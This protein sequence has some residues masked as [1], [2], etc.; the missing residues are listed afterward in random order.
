MICPVGLRGMPSLDDTP[1][2]RP[3]G[4]LDWQQVDASRSWDHG[5]SRAARSPPPERP[6]VDRS[7]V[8]A[9]PPARPFAET[10]DAELIGVLVDPAA[11]DAEPPR[12]LRGA[13]Q[14][15]AGRSI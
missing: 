9:Q 12:D 13:E 2:T 1:P 11:L 14:A 15:G 3:R 6:L 5:R 8:E 10:H 4:R 7:G